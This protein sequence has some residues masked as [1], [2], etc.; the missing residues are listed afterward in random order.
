[1]ATQIDKAQKNILVVED[2]QM[3]TRI[4]K[5]SIEAD[6][7]FKVVAKVDPIVQTNNTLI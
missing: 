4:L 5:A 3:F 2:S 6:S 1:M 7:Q